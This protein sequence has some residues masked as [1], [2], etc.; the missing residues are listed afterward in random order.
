MS[1]IIVGF[2]SFRQPALM[3]LGF[4][5]SLPIVNSTLENKVLTSIA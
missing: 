4:Y 3:G 2:L 1:A 5:G